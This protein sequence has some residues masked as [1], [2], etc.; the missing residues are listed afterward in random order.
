M[1]HELA[2]R[3]LGDV[4]WGRCW[5]HPLSRHFGTVERIDLT[6]YADFENSDAAAEAV[7]G[8]MRT[9]NGDH[10]IDL[11][12]VRPDGRFVA[13]EVKLAG[14]VGDKDGKHLRWVQSQFGDR[15]LDLIIVNTGP[16]AY[17]RPDGIGVV[18]LALL[19][20]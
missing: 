5:L 10:E 13:I 4:G 7:T 14:A 9:R 6:S 3:R 16:S 20:P 17:R 15:V 8:H 11:V 1:P 2:P 19:G 12:V 18:P